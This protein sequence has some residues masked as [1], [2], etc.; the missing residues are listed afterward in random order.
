MVLYLVNIVLKYNVKET[1][2]V[3]KKVTTAQIAIC[4]VQTISLFP[5]YQIARMLQIRRYCAF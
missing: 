1:K 4:K 2:K 3:T 5:S